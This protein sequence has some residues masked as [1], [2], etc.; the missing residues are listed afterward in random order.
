MTGLSDDV[1]SA[2]VAEVGCSGSMAPSVRAAISRVDREQ[3]V[4]VRDV[5]TLDDIAGPQP[6]VIGSAPSW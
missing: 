3:L 1:F 2:G 6:G 4:S 5:R